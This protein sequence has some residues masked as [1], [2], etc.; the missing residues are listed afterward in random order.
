M[1]S[2]HW[3]VIP[4][5]SAQSITQLQLVLETKTHRKAEISHQLELYLETISLVDQDDN[6]KHNNSCSNAP[7]T[8]PLFDGNMPTIDG[9]VNPSVQSIDKCFSTAPCTSLL[10]SELDSSMINESP[11]GLE[12]DHEIDE[13]IGGSQSQSFYSTNIIHPCNSTNRNGHDSNMFVNVS[14]SGMSYCA[15]S[16]PSVDL[17][18]SVPAIENIFSSHQSSMTINTMT[19]KRLRMYLR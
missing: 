3:P 17:S 19:C 18:N 11:K 7:L 9:S 2:G 4:D 13:S 5:D 1:Q 16:Q 6:A 8:S 12:L 14:N 15:N 10:A